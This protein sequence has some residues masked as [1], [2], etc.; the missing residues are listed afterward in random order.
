MSLLY[1]CFAKTFH[2]ANRFK[3]L[4]G[5]E[6]NFEWDYRILIRSNRYIC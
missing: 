4:I 2:F 6:Q 3:S 5:R 1:F